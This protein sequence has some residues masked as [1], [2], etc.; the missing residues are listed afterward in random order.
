M[1][2]R[3]GSEEAS[4]GSERDLYVDF[5]RTG[6]LLVVVIWHWLFNVVD[7]RADGPHFGNPIAQVHG[8]WVLT[9]LF[10]VLPVFFFVGGFAHLVSWESTERRGGGY[11]SFVG[12]RLRRLMIPVAMCLIVAGA[13]RLALELLFPEVRWIGRAIY[14]MLSPLWFMGIYLMLVLLTPLAVKLHRRQGEVVPVVM[15]GLVVLVDVLRFRYRVEGIEWLNLLLVWSMAHQ[16]GFFWRQLVSLSRRQARCLALGGLIGLA[17]LTNIGLYPRS[18]VGVP[19]EAISNM[20]PPTL[21][22]VALMLFQVGVVLLLRPWTQARL[23]EPAVRSYMLWAGQRAMTIYLWHFPGFAIAYA[24][25][26]LAA[27]PVPETPDATWWAQR[28][29]WAVLPALCTIPLVSLFRRFEQ[30]AA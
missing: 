15:G 21:C 4:V 3:T 22:I 7:W 18:M 10:Q 9:W 11:R 1:T 30:K 12:K 2:A 25:L 29:L 24:L 26:A 6:S 13:A 17:G 28:P 8:F 20:G 14:L 16:L 27:I 5:L 23:R 19:G